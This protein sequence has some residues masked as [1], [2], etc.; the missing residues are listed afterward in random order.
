MVGVIRLKKQGAWA[1]LLFVVGT[2]YAS[3]HAAE[4]GDDH[5]DHE[6]VPCLL[7]L[8]SDEDHALIPPSDRSGIPVPS[9][10]ERSVA[11]GCLEHK[12]NIEAVWPPPTGPPLAQ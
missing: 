10:V 12:Q 6:G 2:L 5:H 3:A 8:A 4:H 9:V 1:L 7:L 11:P